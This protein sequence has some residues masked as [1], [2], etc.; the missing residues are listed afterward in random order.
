M[1]PTIFVHRERPWSQWR[2][3]AASIFTAGAMTAA[4][5][6]QGDLLPSFSSEDDNTS[7]QRYEQTVSTADYRLQVSAYYF[8]W[9]G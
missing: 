2:L 3:P 7:S 1:K 5:S 4:A 6:A 8:G 9:S